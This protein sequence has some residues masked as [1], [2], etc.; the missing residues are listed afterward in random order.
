MLRNGETNE[1]THKRTH[2]HTHGHQTHRTDWID[3]VMVVISIASTV[4][5]TVD[6]PGNHEA[7][8]LTIYYIGGLFP[9]VVFDDDGASIYPA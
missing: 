4:L 7:I 8:D 1:H 9:L 3:P 6:Q 5:A 2:T